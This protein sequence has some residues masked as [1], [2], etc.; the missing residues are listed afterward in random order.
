MLRVWDHSWRT[1]VQHVFIWFVLSNIVTAKPKEC[2]PFVMLKF[3]LA[4]YCLKP[5][6]CWQW[7]RKFS[8]LCSWIYLLGFDVN[9]VPHLWGYWLIKTF[10]VSMLCF[11]EHTW[12]H[13]KSAGLFV[14]W[15]LLEAPKANYSACSIAYIYLNLIT[16]EKLKY[17]FIG[18]LESNSCQKH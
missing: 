14:L 3:G 1:I 10:C 6:G 16:E 11:S 8:Q 5:S 15:L 4:Q 12:S 18:Y 17:Q 2:Y 13:L 9:T 7:L